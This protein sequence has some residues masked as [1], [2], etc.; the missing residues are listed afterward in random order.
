MEFRKNRQLRTPYGHNLLG[1]DF[2]MMDRL[3]WLVVVVCYLFSSEVSVGVFLRF[4]SFVLV[5]GFVLAFLWAHIWHRS[6]RHGAMSHMSQG[7]R[8]P[9]SL[10]LT[11]TVQLP[12]YSEQQDHNRIN[13]LLKGRCSNT[14]CR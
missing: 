8:D 4:F 3:T 7:I 1:K 2:V 9:S 5:V 6:F 10:S 13:D 12:L 14:D 11:G